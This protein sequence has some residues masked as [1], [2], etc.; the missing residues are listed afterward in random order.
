[1]D[2][3]GHREVQGDAVTYDVVVRVDTRLSMAWVRL[4]RTLRFVVGASRAQRL[5]LW[6]ANRLA[7]VYVDGVRL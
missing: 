7:R 4:V 6:G 1:M 2:R 3:R 5:A